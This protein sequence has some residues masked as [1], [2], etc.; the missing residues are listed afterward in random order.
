[1]VSAMRYVG[2]RALG[3]PLALLWAAL[4]AMLQLAPD[5]VHGAG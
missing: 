3:V 4:A 1:M 2:L 5:L